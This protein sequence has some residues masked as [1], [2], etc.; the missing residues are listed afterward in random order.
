MTRKTRK[1]RKQSN[2]SVN[3]T[4]KRFP[5][6]TIVRPSNTVAR[7]L[8]TPYTTWNIV[9]SKYVAPK[10]KPLQ[11]VHAMEIGCYK[12]DATTWIL[13]H[14]MKH[15]KSTLYA[16]DTFTGS[17]EYKGLAFNK[18]ESAFYKNIQATHRE[19]QVNVMKMTSFEALLQLNT[20]TPLPQFDLIFI[21]ASH[22]ARDVMSDAVLS[23][24]LLK[25]GGIL[26]FDDYTWHKLQPAWYCPKPAIDAF[27]YAYRPFLKLHAMKSQVL[28]EKTTQQDVP[29]HVTNPHQQKFVLK[30][31]R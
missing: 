17:P 25:V 24:P 20:R 18:I 31:K 28:V 6:N 14:L 3:T 27:L 10:G 1:T 5:T 13:T 9:L 30:R 22:E 12:G 2:R 19:N 15:S 29:Q 16:I 4:L 23:F 8:H 7:R 21:D 11:E 26:I